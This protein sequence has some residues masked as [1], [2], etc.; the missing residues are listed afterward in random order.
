MSRR[1]KIILALTVAAVLFGAYSFLGTPEEP[2]APGNGGQNMESLNAYV[3]GIAGSLPQLTLSETE[4]YVIASAAARWPEDPFLRTQAPENQ[5]AAK[6]TNTKPADE[7]DLIYTGYIEMMGRRIAVINGRE[8]V[9]GD[10][11]EISGYIVR[12]IDPDE[13]K[14]ENPD[15]GKT[16]DV[17]LEQM[18][19]RQGESPPPEEKR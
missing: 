19:T 2:M 18:F 12:R 8:Y 14:I 15:S 13:V 3:L 11:L 10:A 9:E 16:V 1:E 4:N 17:P 7:L 5:T 6:A